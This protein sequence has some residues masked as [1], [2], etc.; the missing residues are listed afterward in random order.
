MSDK[1]DKYERIGS[2]LGGAVVG[3]FVF[4]CIALKLLDWYELSLLVLLT[5]A[6]L[7]AVIGAY[8]QVK[9]GDTLWHEISRFWW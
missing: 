5:I 3:F 9:R 1:L 4:G 7:G 8:S 6:I 2:I